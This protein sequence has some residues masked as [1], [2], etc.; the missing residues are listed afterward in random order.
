[1]GNCLHD[2]I[3]NIS[4]FGMSKEIMIIAATQQPKSHILMWKI[5]PGNSQTYGILSKY[6]NQK[7]S[8]WPLLWLIQWL[9]KVSFG[10]KIYC[11][12]YLYKNSDDIKNLPDKDKI[13]YQTLQNEWLE[14]EIEKCD[15]TYCIIA[16]HHP[17]FSIGT[18]GYGQKIL[19]DFN[20]CAVVLAVEI[21]F[22]IDCTT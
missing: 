22:T 21:F 11:N 4:I 15:S 5:R 6:E 7:I 8:Q 16:G 12:I 13:D 18:H 3:S 20:T 17:M 9:C 19:P 2:K 1:M 14:I 10:I